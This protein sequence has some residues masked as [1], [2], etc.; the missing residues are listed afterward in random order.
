MCSNSATQGGNDGCLNTYE[1]TNGV[2]AS[3]T[4]NIYGIY[5]LSGSAW[6]RV[7]AYVDN[8][9]SNLVG[10][11]SSIIKAINKYKDIYAKG[12]TDDTPNNYSLAI[13]KKGDAVYETSNNTY[14]SYS[15]FNDYSYMPTTGSPWFDRG[16][17]WSNGGGAGAFYFNRSGGGLNSYYG[18]RPVLVVN[19]GL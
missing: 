15:W 18:F 5:D 11:G 1:S 19:A 16:G 6:E 10:Q 12:I 17:A 13:N 8:G 2:K 7:S 4:G 9:H 14:G 3:T